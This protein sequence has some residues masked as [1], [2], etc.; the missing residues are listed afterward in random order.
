MKLN[1]VNTIWIIGLIISYTVLILA[2][3]KSNT[4][5]KQEKDVSN[6]EA[7]QFALLW[8]GGMQIEKPRIICEL[9]SIGPTKICSV[10]G[11]NMKAP[12]SIICNN[13][14]FCYVK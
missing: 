8:A 4:N 11:D 2:V 13:N 10:F 7:E 14:A 1:I 12:I 3:I 9:T 5:I 6:T